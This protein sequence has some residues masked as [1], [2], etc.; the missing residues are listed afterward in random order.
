MSLDSNSINIIQQNLEVL[1]LVEIDRH[2]VFS[3]VFDIGNKN[4]KRHCSWCFRVS[5]TEP[6]RSRSSRT[7]EVL[8]ET[9]M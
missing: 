9:C 1:P 7:M 6:G 5:S 8:W 3:V 2:A 4:V